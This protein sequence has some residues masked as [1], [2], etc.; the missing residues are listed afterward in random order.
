MAVLSD[1]DL[2]RILIKT[3]P[4]NYGVNQIAI[5]VADS[6]G[7][8]SINTDATYSY[9]FLTRGMNGHSIQDNRVITVAT[10]VAGVITYTTA[11]AHN[12][13][14][15]QKVF[16]NG[17]AADINF[18]FT[19]GAVVS[20]VPSSTTFSVNSS[21]ANGLSTVNG[22]VLCFRN[23]DLIWIGASST[24]LS[25]VLGVNAVYNVFDTGSSTASSSN[26]GKGVTGTNASRFQGREAY[27]SLYV[28]DTT[29]ST[30]RKIRDF[31]QIFT[32]DYGWYR[33]TDKNSTY[34]I[35]KYDK[36]RSTAQWMLNHLPDFYKYNSSNTYNTDLES[37][38]SLFAFH[39]DIYRTAADLVYSRSSSSQI[40]KTLL[41]LFLKELGF[42]P[43]NL[44]SDIYLSK[45][46]LPNIIRAYKN[47]GSVYGLALI[48]ELL[49]G[50]DS[51]V[52]V[53]D[54]NMIPDLNAASAIEGPL[55]SN[56]WSLTP[57]VVA[58]RSTAT[59]TAAL[60]R[61]PSPYYSLSYTSY[62]DN[63][64]L[65]AQITNTTSST[66]ITSTPRGMVPAANIPAGSTT[67]TVNHTTARVGDYVIS[68]PSFPY[69]PVGASITKIVSPAN[70]VAVG[71]VSTVTINTATVGGSIPGPGQAFLTTSAA[72]P[73][74]IA[75]ASKMIPVTPGQP[76][77]FSF[78]VNPF[79]N[80][81]VPVTARIDFYTIDGLINTGSVAG[82]PVTPSS[83]NSWTR[84]TVSGTATSS[85]IAAFYAAPGISVANT[86]VVA[87]NNCHF[88]ALQ[89]EKG[90]TATPYFDPG[91][92][93]VTMTAPT[94]VRRL[95]TSVLDRA[96]YVAKDWRVSSFIP[97]TASG[98]VDTATSIDPPPTGP[99]SIAMPSLADPTTTTTQAVGMITL[100][101]PSYTIYPG[102]TFNV[103]MV[104]NTSSLTYNV[105]HGMIIG[106]LSPTQ[107]IFVRRDG[108]PTI[109]STTSSLNGNMRIN[110]INKTN[111]LTAS[112]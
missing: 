12:L 21:A 100:A 46:M 38:I 111:Y 58:N 52:S 37:F 90:L 97:E 2:A 28:I 44:D 13:S 109:T 14:A 1:V 45:K 20:S 31:S 112:A 61:V 99:Y 41:S 70:P 47:R 79:G 22:R 60:S 80:T 48:Y 55:A 62:V 34:G 43:K 87:T 32:R 59:T 39:L 40:D 105:T 8:S 74:A 77:T 3:R 63:G 18:G 84:V 49:T 85:P 42:N 95:L 50:Y 73:D 75:A 83:S 108:G 10:G 64:I 65:R 89:F 106:A 24:S 102:Q 53:G 104:G 98:Y 57:T 66:G 15:G 11:T 101:G 107:Y 33:S 88:D 67:F 30:A 54:T 78:Y 72:G 94:A 29:S 36:N 56:F 23:G 6:A 96:K 35:W 103:M 26:P 110:F 91:Y 51:S 17:T 4:S 71:A 68:D 86:T 27:Y 7:N 16:I 82:T 93:Q 69:I 81:I 5:G 19:S 25:N 9:M 76:Y 92:T